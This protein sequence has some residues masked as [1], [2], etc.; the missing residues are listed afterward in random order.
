[1]MDDSNWSTPL[2]HQAFKDATDKFPI[3]ACVPSGRARLWLHSH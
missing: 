3:G 1:M 2:T